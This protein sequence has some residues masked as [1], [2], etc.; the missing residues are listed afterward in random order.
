MAGGFVISK[1][2]GDW[3]FKKTDDKTIRGALKP[4]AAFKEI[5]GLKAQ[6]GW[7]QLMNYFVNFTMGSSY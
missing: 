6:M 7:I 3:I 5:G 1:K 2:N 4:K